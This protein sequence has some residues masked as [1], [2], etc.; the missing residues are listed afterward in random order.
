MSEPQVEKLRG[1]TMVSKKNK[2]SRANRLT[3][4]VVVSEDLLRSLDTL[5]GS[6]LPLAVPRT[7][8]IRMLLEEALSAR[9]LWDNGKGEL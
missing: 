5:V 7:A 9:K 4:P 1:L 3:V 8:V 6:Y 2:R